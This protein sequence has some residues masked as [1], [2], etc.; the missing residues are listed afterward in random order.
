MKQQYKALV[1]VARD[2][3]K[4]RYCEK[5]HHT[6]VACALETKNG[7]VYS[8]LNVGTYQPSIATCAEIIAIGMALKDDPKMTIKAIV[9]VRD[10]DGYVVS[11][12][13]KCREYIADYGPKAI[14]LTPADNADGYQ[15]VSIQELLPCKYCKR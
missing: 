3:I 11:S 1:K 12:C 9:S 15:P 14:V 4:K 10:K 6:V 2:L 8:A 7:K 13:G 5:G